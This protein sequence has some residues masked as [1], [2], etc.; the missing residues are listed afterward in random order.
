[1]KFLS[2]NARRSSRSLEIRLFV[3]FFTAGIAAGIEQL[4]SKAVSA[5]PDLAV[6]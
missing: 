2:G 5:L 6:N 3:P 1:M 4:K